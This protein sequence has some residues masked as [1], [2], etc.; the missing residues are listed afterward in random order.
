MSS[1]PGTT[2]CFHGNPATVTSFNT[3]SNTSSSVYY[4]SVPSSLFKSP[5][6]GTHLLSSPSFV[7]LKPKK[8]PLW[9]PRTLP[10]PSLVPH[11][12]DQEMQ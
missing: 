7:I 4:K 3:P 10:T 9:G 6:L 5:S 11:V 2:Q 12:T 8:A 1:G